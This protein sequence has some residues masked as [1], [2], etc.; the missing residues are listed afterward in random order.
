MSGNWKHIWISKSAF[1]KIP[2]PYKELVE[3][4]EPGEQRVVSVNDIQ[5]VCEAIEI[6]NG[7]TKTDGGRISDKRSY[8]KLFV[9]QLIHNTSERHGLRGFSPG[10]GPHEAIILP[11]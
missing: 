1:G 3:N 4:T 9:A 11:A 10:N 6:V 7:L 8:G 5:S 2:P